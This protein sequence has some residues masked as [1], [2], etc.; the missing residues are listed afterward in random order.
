MSVIEHYGRDFKRFERT[1]KS[2]YELPARRMTMIKAQLDAMNA[3]ARLC[4]VV[5]VHFITLFKVALLRQFH[6]KNEFHGLFSARTASTKRWISSIS[7]PTS[8]QTIS[9]SSIKSKL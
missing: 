9:F 5:D 4:T 6:M 8:F 7:G 2:K 1:V 3:G